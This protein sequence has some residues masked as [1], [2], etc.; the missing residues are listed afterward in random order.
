ML[1]IINVRLLNYGDALGWRFDTDQGNQEKRKIFDFD[2]KF[3]SI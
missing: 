1:L 2:W 3:K